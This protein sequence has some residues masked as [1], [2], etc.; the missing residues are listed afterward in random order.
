MQSLN[1]SRD[2]V[3]FS[4]TRRSAQMVRAHPVGC[5]LANAPSVGRELPEDLS[6]HAGV[7]RSGKKLYFQVDTACIHHINKHRVQVWLLWYMYDI[8]PIFERLQQSMSD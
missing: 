6:Y 1:D 3:L 4:E 5:R 8:A 2:V 7:K